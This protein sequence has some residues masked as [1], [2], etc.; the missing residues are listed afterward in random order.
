M[1]LKDRIKRKLTKLRLRPIH[2]FCFHHVSDVFEEET[3]I[4]IDWLQTDVFKDEINRLRAIGYTFISL[5]EAHNHLQHDKYRRRKYAVLTAD[6]GWA[7]LK[8]ILPWLNEQNIPVTL[9]LNPPYLDGEHY[10][11]KDTESYLTWS[12]VE[13]ISKEY[14]LVT[15]GS[16]G[17]EHID[18]TKQTLAE[19]EQNVTQSIDS[20]KSL[21]NYIPF[22]AFPYGRNTDEAINIVVAL[23]HIPLLV[24]G[25][26][27]VVAKAYIDRELLGLRKVK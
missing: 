23:K 24:S 4:K 10:R 8:N 19:F 15:I 11:E 16:H 2:V 21:P 9:F 26:W 1:K 12:D 3:M 22:Y 18:A 27:N 7:S 17:M 5:S 14:P 13:N 6:D 25:N 20:L